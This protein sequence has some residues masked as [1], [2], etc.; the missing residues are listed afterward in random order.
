MN[1][2]DKRSGAGG[3]SLRLFRLGRI[4]LNIGPNTS[5]MATKAAAMPQVERRNWRRSRPNLR[6]FSSAKSLSRLSTLRWSA[7]CGSGLNSPFDTICIGTGDG[8]A[9]FQRL[10]VH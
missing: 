9:V 4:D 5:F 2:P 6:P 8:N 10:K 1:W 3:T 7:V